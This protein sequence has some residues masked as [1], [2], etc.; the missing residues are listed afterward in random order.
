MDDFVKNT[1]S[2]LNRAELPGM[3]LIEHLEELRKRMIHAA[4]WLAVGFAYAFHERLYG[5]VQA[6]LDQLHIPLN[7]THPTDGLTL[8]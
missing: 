5:F 1:R 4:I 6:P 8:T 3:S 7:F 2:T